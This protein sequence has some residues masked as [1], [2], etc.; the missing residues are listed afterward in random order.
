MDR[1]IDMMKSAGWLNTWMLLAGFA[2]YVLLKITYDF[3]KCQLNPETPA[4][5]FNLW[6]KNNGI[7][8][9]LSLLM[10][11]MVYVTIYLRGKMSPEIAGAIGTGGTVLFS[12]IFKISKLL[13][14]DKTP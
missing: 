2:V 5:S 8:L 13:T 11:L 10:T 4:F 14:N 3:K 6:I 12:I 9:L 7:D 1:F